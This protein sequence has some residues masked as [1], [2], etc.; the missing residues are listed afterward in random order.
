MSGLTAT[1]FEA[2]RL[3]E[4]EAEIFTAV[5]AAFG[6]INRNDDG[7]LRQLIGIFSEREAEL[8][9]LLS[10]L[11]GSYYPSAA[12]SVALD[13]VA[14]LA[15]LERIAAAKSTAVIAA[16]GTASTV[17][18]LGT[19]F[20]PSATG[21]VFESDAAVT[22]LQTN[23]VRNVIEVTTADNSQ[24]FTI[25]IDGTPY[26]FVSDATA[27]KQEIVTGL[28][29]ALA[30][31]SA[32]MTGVDDGTGDSLTLT[33]NDGETGYNVTVSATGAGVL[34]VNEIWTPVAVTALVAGAN[35]V[36]AGQIDTI[37]TPVSGLDQVEQ[38]ADGVQGRDTE[39]DAELR[40]RITGARLGEATA[41]AIRSRILNEVDGVTTVLV[42]ENTTDAA[43]GGQPA[44]SIHVIVQGGADQ[45]IADKLWELK[46]A[47]IATYGSETET[48]V[49][50]AGNSQ[51]VYFS[52]PTS[53]YAWVR[54][55]LTKY[56]EET[57]PTDGDD[58]IA[59]A[60]LAYGN[61]FGIGQDLLWQRFLTPVFETN[62]VKS[63]SV[64]LDTTAGAG[65]PPSY[66]TN[67]DVAVAATDLAVFD[68]TRITII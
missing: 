38:I 3:T 55:T 44:H 64:E 40:I 42:I 26:A 45:D 49:D 58:A 27:T 41:E 54:V 68:A 23:S 15:G 1:G 21:D 14:E 48:V 24:T 35:L 60:I 2:K 65:G 61:T 22:I 39:T 30:T 8:W 10:A 28:I 59:A 7:F 57:Y 37:V 20:S 18:P 12:E 43:V 56:S 53:Q 16:E 25:T 63:A 32:P 52:R 46:P 13:N 47:G 33:A 31:G 50:G 11:Y 67:T 51:T 9:E 36:N 66:V 19:Q 5:E 4:I 29:A 6:P 17:I 34:T 62:G